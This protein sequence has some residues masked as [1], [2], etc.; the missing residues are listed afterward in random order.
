[1]WLRIWG[2]TDF[3]KWWLQKHTNDSRILRVRL[4]FCVICHRFNF[5]FPPPPSYSPHCGVLICTHSLFLSPAVTLDLFVLQFASLWNKQWP[6]Q[7]HLLSRFFMAFTFYLAFGRS[8]REK[9][10]H[11]SFHA[12]KSSLPSPSTKTLKK[13]TR[14]CCTHSRSTWDKVNEVPCQHALS[15]CTCSM[16]TWRFA[17][18]TDTTC[19]LLA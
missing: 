6:L 15:V 8:H 5:L 13:T 14:S 2:S 7:P 16:Y 3:V 11:L 18:L 12:S 9:V 1:M 17:R 4:C 10:K 19:T